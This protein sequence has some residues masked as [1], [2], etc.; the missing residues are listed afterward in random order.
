MNRTFNQLINQLHLDPKK[1]AAVRKIV[2]NAISNNQSGNNNSGGYTDMMVLNTR[3]NATLTEEQ[4]NEIEERVKNGCL[5]ELQYHEPDATLSY[6]SQGQK[7]NMLGDT[8]TYIFNNNFGAASKDISYIGDVIFLAI[9]TPDGYGFIGMPVTNLP[10]SEIPIV[11]TPRFY[12]TGDGTKFLSDDGT[13]KEVSGGSEPYIWDGATNESTN[14]ELKQ[15]ILDNRRIICN[16]INCVGFILGESIIIKTNSPIGNT[17]FVITNN[18]VVEKNADNFFIKS[19]YTMINSSNYHYFE[20]TQ[21]TILYV[22]TGDESSEFPST[23]E[24]NGEFTFGDTVYNVG[25]SAGLKWSTDSVL[26]YKPNHTYQFRILNN[27]GVM[28]EFAN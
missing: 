8:P 3:D 17:I 4:F 1:E 18:N 14:A 28:K 7:T 6:Y 21:D 16:N 15:A 10:D 26:E 25:F 11:K 12:Y 9:K 22:M 23:N 27:R 24:F 5:F 20:I 13:Y 2:E 19:H